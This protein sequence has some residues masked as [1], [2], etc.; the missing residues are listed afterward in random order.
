M[1]RSERYQPE[2]DGLRAVA[3]TAAV[4]FHAKLSG[5]AGGFVGVD[6]FFVISGFLITR[7]LLSELSQSG[8][9]D[10][11]AFYARRIRRL[12]PALVAV[13]VTV[14][15][16]GTF[17]LSAAGER[18]DL[19]ISAAT[20]FAFVSNFYFWRL[21]AFY[22]A[23]PA[24]WLALLNMWTLSVEEQFYLVWPALLVLAAAIARTTRIR[25]PAIVAAMLIILFAAS[26]TVFLWGATAK[27]TAAFYLTPTRMWEFALGGALALAENSLR[28]LERIAGIVALVG[29]VAIVVSVVMLRP[30]LA[31]WITI[32]PAAFGAAAVIGGVSAMPASLVGRVLATAPFVVVGRLSYS[33]YLW[34]W[35]LLAL[36]RVHDFGQESLPRDLL[37]VFGSLGLSALTYRFLEN[38][39]RRRKPWPF[40]GAWQTVAAG[41]GLSFGVA[42]LALA[43]Y[44]QADAA[45]QLDPWLSGI[46]AARSAEVHSPPTCHLGAKFSGLPPAQSCLVGAAGAP[47]RIL[48][49]GDF[50]AEHLVEMIGAD[51]IRNGYAAIA[52]TM[53]ACPPLLPTQHSE[54]RLW[55]SCLKFNEAVVRE[56]PALARTG[57]TGIVLGSR[58]YG[59][60]G[61]LATAAD[62]AAWRESLRAVLS[63]A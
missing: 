32:L 57:V 49:W 2:I 30:R 20:T 40:S 62:M 50:H 33:W 8:R 51:G 6:V 48:I 1:S 60:R 26:I 36:A 31:Y 52:R 19:S 47:P 17:V 63:M 55:D 28:R 21:Q 45:A 56:M 39:V 5:F 34:H 29:L 41:A 12:L 38:P 4:L 7:M 54:M 44:V 59:F 43:L 24:E 11:V 27:P 46:Y 58:Q 53:S 37:V 25:G 15:V 22:F 10:F 61:P 23:G 16:L 13:V 3:I 35:P 9:I 18:Q 42:V 14:L